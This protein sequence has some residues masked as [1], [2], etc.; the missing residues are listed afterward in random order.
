MEAKLLCCHQI[1]NY[2][3]QNAICAK[4]EKPWSR[5]AIHELHS[6]ILPLV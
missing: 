4:V 3:T 1:K 6:E 5:C 2:L